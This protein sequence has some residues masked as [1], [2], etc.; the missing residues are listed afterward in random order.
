VCTRTVA[1]AHTHSR[2]AAAGPRSWRPRRG[3]NGLWRRPADR[4]T[5]MVDP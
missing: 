3:P 2:R 5:V 4:A 1:Q